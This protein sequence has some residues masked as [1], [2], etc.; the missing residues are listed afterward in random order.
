[1]DTPADALP[2]IRLPDVAKFGYILLTA[3][4]LIGYPWAIEAWPENWWWDP[5]I[6]SSIMM[7]LF[8]SAYLHIRIYS[9]KKLMWHFEAV[10]GVL[11]YVSLVFT[12]VMSY[13]FK[14]E[15]TL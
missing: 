3:G 11:C 4:M 13:F 5:K 1:M 10:L 14:G 6:C 15:H 8:Y 7:W 2:G 12:Y 9:H